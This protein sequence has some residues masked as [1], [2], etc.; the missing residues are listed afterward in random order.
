MIKLKKFN[1]LTKIIFNIKV[2]NFCN[3]LQQKKN[4]KMEKERER[5]REKEVLV[6]G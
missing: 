3:L 4:Q 1:Y 5:E 2:I 6:E